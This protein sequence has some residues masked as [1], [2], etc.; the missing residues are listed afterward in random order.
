MRTVFFE[1]FNR[2]STESMVKGRAS[3]FA[4]STHDESVPNNREPLEWALYAIIYPE[5]VVDPRT[6]NERS[7]TLLMKIFQQNTTGVLGQ[8]NFPTKTRSERQR[9]VNWLR[10]NSMSSRQ[11]DPSN[12]SSFDR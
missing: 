7:Q 3:T 5:P 12:Y 11:A 1:V 9:R 4:A 10:R 8:P 2:C 6:P